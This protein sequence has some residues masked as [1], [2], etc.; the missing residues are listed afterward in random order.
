MRFS[1]VSLVLPALLGLLGAPAQN[2]HARPGGGQPARQRA[3]QYAGAAGDDRDL[4][5]ER[6]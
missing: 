5:F 4:A 6:E 1:N 2:A 3:T